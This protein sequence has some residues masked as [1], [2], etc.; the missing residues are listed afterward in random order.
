MVNIFSLSAPAGTGG[1]ADDEVDGALRSVINHGSSVHRCGWMGQ[2]EVWALSHDEVLGVY[3]DCG[4]GE[5]HMLGDVRESMGAEYVVDVLP[6]G[7]GGWVVAGNKEGVWV[8]FVPLEGTGEKWGLGNGGYRL[9]E[10]RMGG[11]VCRDVVVDMEVYLWLCTMV[12]IRLIERDRR[13][14]YLR[15]ERTGWLK[16]GDHRRRQKKAQR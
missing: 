16:R 3:G 8:D 15:A 14:R 7:E 6:R 10:G 5:A 1:E 9:L 4:E 12:G 13:I 2:G 11:E